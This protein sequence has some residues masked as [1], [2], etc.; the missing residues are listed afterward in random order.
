MLNL[1]EMFNRLMVLEGTDKRMYRKIMKSIPYAK[2]W[3]REASMN[4][5]LATAMCYDGS[6]PGNIKVLV[7]LCLITPISYKS[8]AASL[9]DL[10]RNGE[11]PGER[12]FN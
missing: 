5:H 3:I 1:C 8:T 7:T 2:V 11:A 12:L 4:I 6:K 10:R 9:L